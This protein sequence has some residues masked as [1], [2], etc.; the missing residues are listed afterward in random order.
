LSFKSPAEKA[1]AGFSPLLLH[2]KAYD[3]PRHEDVWRS[4][5]TAHEFFISTLAAE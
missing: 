2:I 3:A 4:E 1:E 5:G